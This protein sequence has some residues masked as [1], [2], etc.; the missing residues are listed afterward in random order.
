MLYPQ[1]KN[2]YFACSVKILFYVYDSIKQSKVLQ[3]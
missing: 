3:N 1:K 2:I